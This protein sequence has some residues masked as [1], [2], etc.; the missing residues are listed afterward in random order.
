MQKK[1]PVTSLDATR[2]AVAESSKLSTGNKISIS[3]QVIPSNKMK[4]SEHSKEVQAKHHAQKQ[5]HSIVESDDESVE[6]M[7][8]FEDEKDSKPATSTAFDVAVDYGDD[9]FFQNY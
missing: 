4:L 5:S 8:S 9:N 2:A 3:E 1:I 7:E 6:V